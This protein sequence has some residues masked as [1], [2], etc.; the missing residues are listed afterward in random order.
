MVKQGG[1]IQAIVPLLAEYSYPE[2]NF[3]CFAMYGD[4]TPLPAF[5]DDSEIKRSNVVEAIREEIASIVSEYGIHYGKF[6]IDPLVEC[7]YFKDFSAFNMMDEGAQL[8]F[9]T[10][11]IV[12]L[13]LPEDAILRKMRKGHK[14]A[15][16]QI[17]RDAGYSVEIF[18]SSNAD[19]SKLLEFKEIHKTDAGRQ[20]RTDKSWDC[21]YE[22]IESG[23]ACLVML[24]L[25][26]SPSYCAAALMM[27]YKKSA[28][29]ASYATLDAAC[30]NGHIGDIIQWEAIKYLKTRGIERYEMGDNYY[31]APQTDN[32]RKLLEIARYKK[33]FRSAEIPKITYFKNY[34]ED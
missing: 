14:A 17:I 6:I 22:W 11:N 4:Y 16:K 24:K 10:T 2:R 30:L 3:D 1:Q 7:E 31:F 18:D 12:D 5:A 28:Y 19:K 27:I 9:S 32:D 25:D 15:I 20:T 33:G 13:T 8:H 26:G 21:M 29:Y 23:N 34:V